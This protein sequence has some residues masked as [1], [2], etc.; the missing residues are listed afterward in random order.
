M[1][2]ASRK[3]IIAKKTMKKNF[4]TPNSGGT[5]PAGAVVSESVVIGAVSLQCQ[6]HAKGLPFLCFVIFRAAV[7]IVALQNNS[8]NAL[9]ESTRIA[10]SFLSKD[11][12]ISTLVSSYFSAFPFTQQVLNAQGLSGGAH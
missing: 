7:Q 10:V 12:S 3:K 8:P 11:A 2:W 9:M 1:L 6:A 4:P 5:R